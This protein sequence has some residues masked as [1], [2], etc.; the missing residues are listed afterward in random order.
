[1][2]KV[3][4]RI[5]LKFCNGRQLRHCEVG[6]RVAGSEFPVRS[7]AN[8]FRR[9]YGGEPAHS[10]RSPETSRL[11]YQGGKTDN[12][13]NHVVEDGM[14]RRHCLVSSETCNIRERYFRSQSPHSIAGAGKLRNALEAKQCLE[15]EGRKVNIQSLKVRWNETGN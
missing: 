7:K 15:K 14:E 6:W 3:Y 9:D 11:R 8:L 1:M 13:T 2:V 12:L 10:W 4:M 5:N